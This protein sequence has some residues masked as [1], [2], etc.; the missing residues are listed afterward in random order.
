MQIHYGPRG[1]HAE[2][3]SGFDRLITARPKRR[4]RRPHRSGAR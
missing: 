3:Q 4:I 2:L 1:V